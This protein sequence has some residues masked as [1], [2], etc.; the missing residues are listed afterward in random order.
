MLKK[1]LAGLPVTEQEQAQLREWHR[2]G[3]LNNDLFG[4]KDLE[5]A[6]LTYLAAVTDKE[7]NDKALRRFMASANFKDRSVPGYNSMPTIH[8]IHFL[9]RWGSA[10]AAILILAVGIVTIVIRSSDRQPKPSNT[11]KVS[12]ASPDILPGTNKALLTLSDGTTLNLDSTANGAIAQQG[13]SSIVKLPNGRIVYDL[14]GT[15]QGQVM[16]NTM[17]TPRGGQYQLV[18]PDGT[19]VWLNAASSIIYPAV[20]VGNDRKVKVSGEVYMEVA[21]DK[22]RPF[23]VDVDGKSVVQVLGT[24]FNINSYPDEGNIKTTLV[25]GS[26]RVLPSH[27]FP[28]MGRGVVLKPGQQAVISD[29]DPATTK[30]LSANIGQALAWKNGI[31]DF[32]DA[33][34]Q[35]VMKQL[36]RWYD[37]DVKFEHGLPGFK[38]EGQVDRG[39]KLSGIVRFLNNF[40]V[41]TRL[42]GRTL[43]ISEK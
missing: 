4:E 9:R 42:E 2:Q 24:G 12:V 5:Q 26:V 1:R 38:T 23:L 17:R 31:F 14:K 3:E 43:I 22:A 40:G 25:E 28:G 6:V 32:D 29:N 20:F 34:L 33:D 27:T 11:P 8:R 7:N 41:N 10:A 13:N 19:R 37:I 15:S 18:L 35:T 39:V 21:K 30:V 16:M 36:E